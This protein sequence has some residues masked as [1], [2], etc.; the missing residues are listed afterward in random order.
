MQWRWKSY[1]VHG[2]VAGHKLD[3]R[4]KVT[5][6]A[7]G[8]AHGKAAERAQRGDS[9]RRRERD[10]LAQSSGHKR[11]RGGQR[12]LSKRRVRESRGG[13]QR[14]CIMTDS[15]TRAG[16]WSGAWKCNSERS[17][18]NSRRTCV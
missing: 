14:T 3:A 10:V 1:L 8:D 4:A 6:G 12:P 13:M 11:K 5:V 16:S 2:K 17:D 18:A 15:E 9:T 7:E